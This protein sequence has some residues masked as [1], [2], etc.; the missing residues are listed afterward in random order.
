MADQR[1]IRPG[2]QPY[3]TKSNKFRPVRTPGGRLVGQKLVK[4]TAGPKCSDCKSSL[5]GIKHLKLSAYR[6][7]KKRERTVNR[8]Y[9]GSTCG[10]CV[11]QRIVRAFLIE[12]QMVVKKLLKERAK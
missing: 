1:F 6:G 4:K 7:L 10:N 3:N 9:G 12:E 11:R 2:R 5:P 8:A